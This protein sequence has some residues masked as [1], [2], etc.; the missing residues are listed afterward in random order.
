M[1]LSNF[2]FF[3]SVKWINQLCIHICTRNYINSESSLNFVLHGDSSDSTSA[4]QFLLTVIKEKRQ[5]KMS[6][7]CLICVIYY[8]SSIFKLPL[9]FRRIGPVQYWFHYSWQIT[10]TVH[11]TIKIEVQAVLMIPGFFSTKSIFAKFST[12]K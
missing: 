7:L 3:G 10:P 2:Y 8:C 11:I 6:Q 4:P 5:T 1:H 9:N 12:Y